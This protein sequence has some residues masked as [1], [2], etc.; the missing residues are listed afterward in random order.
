MDLYHGY[1]WM[2][3]VLKCEVHDLK[4]HTALSILKPEWEQLIINQTLIL[5]SE[6]VSCCASLIDEQVSVG[7]LQLFATLF[8]VLLLSP[9]LSSIFVLNAV[10]LEGTLKLLCKVL[11]A[12]EK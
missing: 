1:E 7:S 5:A 11:D 10:K 9:V 3:A 6:V 2:V 8:L 12:F 4:F